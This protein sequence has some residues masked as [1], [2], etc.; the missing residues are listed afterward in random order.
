MK[1]IDKIK[2]LQRPAHARRDLLKATLAAITIL[3]LYFY[4]V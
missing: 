4:F 1:T 2:D 3:T